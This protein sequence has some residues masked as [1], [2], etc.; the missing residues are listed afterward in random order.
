MG[1]S[2]ALLYSIKINIKYYVDNNIEI[3]IP[4]KKKSRE[5]ASNQKDL[6]KI[7]SWC[8][9]KTM[10]HFLFLSVQNILIR[11]FPNKLIYQLI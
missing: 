8:N 10:L 11:L 5:Y 9:N 4:F 3:G 6:T 7:N 2:K 1:L